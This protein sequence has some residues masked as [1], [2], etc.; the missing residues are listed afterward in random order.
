MNKII[1]L[2]EKRLES[3]DASILK[4]KSIIEK[5]KSTLK[6]SELKTKQNLKTLDEDEL[7]FI[8][9]FNL[10][11]EKILHSSTK[12]LNTLLNIKKRKIN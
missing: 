11:V 6:K 12:L 7:N 8:K 5:A 1:S 4:T 9:D 3:L 2:Q 10:Q